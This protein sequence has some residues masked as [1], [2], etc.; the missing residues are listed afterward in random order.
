MLPMR[1]FERHVTINEQMAGSLPVIVIIVERPRGF[2]LPTPSSLPD[3]PV[4]PSPLDERKRE[5]RE[6][7]HVS[8][9]ESNCITG[10]RRRRR[11][12]RIGETFRAPFL[13][14]FPALSKYGGEES[15]FRFLGHCH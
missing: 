7:R 6:T 11:R 3:R 15:R 5:R 13:H 8:Q 4:H 10:N 9:W 2:L 12:R 1:S 14:C